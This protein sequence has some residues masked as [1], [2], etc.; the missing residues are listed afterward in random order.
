M[1]NDEQQLL[2]PVKEA[3]QR[4]SLTPWSTYKLCDDGVLESVYQGRRRYVVV[5]SLN[6]YVEGLRE[7]RKSA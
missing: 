6:A 1:S 3:A 5:E 7:V 2:I 4:I